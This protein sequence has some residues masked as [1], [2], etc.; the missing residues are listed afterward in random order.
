MVLGATLG[1]IERQIGTLF[2]ICDP[3]DRTFEPERAPG[4]L[5]LGKGYF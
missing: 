1:R 5:L 4:A 2:E 3:I